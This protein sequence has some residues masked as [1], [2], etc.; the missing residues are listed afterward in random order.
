MLFH[1]V[2][3]LFAF[4]PIVWAVWLLAIHVN[5]GRWVR[6]WLTFASWFFYAYWNPPYLAL[7]LGSICVNFWLGCLVDPLFG[8]KQARARRVLL[9][10]GL[11]FNLGLL[12]YFKYANFFVD[13]M[14]SILGYG[15]NLENVVLPLAISFFTFQQ[16]AYL[17]DSFGGRVR[18]HSFWDYSFFVSFFPQLIAGPIVHH[19][20]IIPQLQRSPES[21]KILRNL[22]VGI[23]IFILG[24]FKKMVLADSCGEWV[25]PVF[26]AAQ[27]GSNFSTADAWLGVLA[28]TFQIYFDFSGYSDMAIGLALMFGLRLPQNFAA[29][30]RATSIVEFWRRWHITLSRFL[31]DYL[32]IPLGGNRY[33]VWM[34]YRNLLITMLLGG[35]WHGAGWTFVIW[36]GLHGLYLAMNHGWNTLMAGSKWHGSIPTWIRQST[37]WVLTMFAVVFAWVFF[38]ADTIQSAAAILDAMAGRGGEASWGTPLAVLAVGTMFERFVVFWF[39]LLAGIILLLPT[40]QSYFRAENPVLDIPD[41]YRKIQKWCWRPGFLHGILSGILLFFVVRKYYSAAPTEFLYFNF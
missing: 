26:A 2:V 36:G 35:L 34:R 24:L 7:L 21:G 30:Y 28:Y 27:A 19:G 1:S 15:W 5:G 38:R 14:S 17:I 40:T 31:R 3:F 37:G 23:S 39:L 18:G 33:G 6:H 16:I 11:A 10:L 4:L 9:Y 12:G 13:T 20:E 29:P 32:Y 22:Q 8:E 41:S 25:G